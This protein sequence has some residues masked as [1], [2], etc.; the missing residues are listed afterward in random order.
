[1]RVF[2]HEFLCAGGLGPGAPESL[3]REGRAMLR[4][5]AEDFACVPGIEVATL[6]ADDEAA[7]PGCVCARVGAG[8][9]E[10]RWRDLV[11]AA[12][13]TLLIAPESGGVLETLSRAV[14]AAG[15]LLLGS[16][17]EAVRLTGDKL[18]T[19]RHWQA[20]GIPTPWTVPCLDAG[21]PRYPAL[22]KPRRGAG[23]QAT[24]L[25]RGA[26][27]WPTVRAA[28]RAEAP[29]EEILA[30][31]YVSGKA[32]SVAL[33]LGP[34]GCVPLAPATQRLSDDGRFRYLGGEVPLPPAL[35]ERATR[36]ALSAVEGITGLR[37]YVG[38]DL[39]LGAV[40]MPIEINP[41]LTTSY[42]GLR[43]L[44]RDNL[45]ALWLRLHH[46]AAIVDTAWR[47]G[48]V[49]FGADGRGRRIFRPRSDA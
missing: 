48:G 19:A 30:Q 2:I 24:F 35:A 22:V 40:D 9:G 6:L 25:V 15:G 12:D 21:P 41:R 39:V 26:A 43:R 20:R 36:L 16:A 32:V 27:D 46:G 4:A 5:V 47:V 34:A 13:A 45:A 14:L 17:P 33:L 44:C 38:V 23:S 37:G 31:D 29:A 49:I 42:V 3:R 28:L 8:D 18:A 11:A 7:V 1:M 10:R